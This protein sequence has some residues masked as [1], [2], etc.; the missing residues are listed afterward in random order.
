[1][2]R[3]PGRGRAVGQAARGRLA[4]HGHFYQP[5]RCDPFSSL[6]PGDPAASPA[7]DW[8]ERITD[9]CYAPNAERGNFG[10]IGWDVGPTLARWLRRERP[11]VHT[12]IVRQ[13]MG[14]NGMA[15]AF[16]HAILPLASVRDRRTEIRWGLRDFELRFGHRS[17]GLWLPETAVDLL[18]LRI[19]AEEGVRY[20]ILAPWQAGVAVDTRRLY[21]V[22]LG[23]GDSMIVAFYDDVLS[24]R[25]SFDPG[26][27]LDADRFALES[28]APALA[29]TAAP[30]PSAGFP[31]APLGTPGD[32]DSPSGTAPGDPHSFRR[33]EVPSL[34]ARPAVVSEELPPLLLIASDG[35]LYGH[36]ATFRDLF[37]ARLTAWHYPGFGVTT[38]GDLV[39]DALQR[40]ESLPLA[41]IRDATSWSCHH[42]IARWSAECP[43][44]RDGRWKQ[45]LRAALD[46]LAARLD[47]V[48]ERECAAMGIDAWAARDAYADVASEFLE[49]GELV[50]RLLGEAVNGAPAR[51][52]AIAGNGSAARLGTLLLAQT[53]RLT[54]F[55]SD[56]WF[57][58]DAAR[59]ET[60]QSLRYAAHAVRLIDDLAG[61]DLETPFVEDL[62]ALHSPGTGADGAELYARALTSI[63]QPAP[64]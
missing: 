58:E 8:N 51:A 53:S 3:A 13:E 33:S 1:M 9:E 7:H 56:A 55:A 48:T 41:T 35:E 50:D 46:R 11:D 19:A 59:P 49:A 10:R 42:G 25:V 38:L 23:G 12:A 63:G 40:E 60:M 61:T 22:E 6:V 31:H 62:T 57:W 54:M 27:T 29:G 26:A 39:A 43:D 32:S 2:K 24:A 16:H 52:Q 21:R 18:T 47:L 17:L 30:Q 34:P 37:L 4:V 44:A 28:V 45:P 20:T 36:H 14:R 15:Q 5:E 64:G